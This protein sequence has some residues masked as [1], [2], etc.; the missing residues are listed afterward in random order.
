MI[1]SAKEA[2]DIPIIASIN[3][4]SASEWIEFAGRIEEAGADAP[5]AEYLFPSH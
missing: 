3:C 1:R 2:V 4:V 5:G